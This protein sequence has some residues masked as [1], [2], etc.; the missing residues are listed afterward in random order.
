MSAISGNLQSWNIE[1]FAKYLVTVVQYARDH[2]GIDVSS[3]EPFNEPDPP[4]WYLVLPNVSYRVRKA[5]TS[6]VIL[7]L[8]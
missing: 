2:W 6:G 1:K 4:S 5:A 7:Q 8:S 3:I